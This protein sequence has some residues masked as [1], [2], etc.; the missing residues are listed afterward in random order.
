MKF[1][2]SS[3]A[4]IPCPSQHDLDIA[5][6]QDLSEDYA[7]RER[8]E[9][10]REIPMSKLTPNPQWDD[11]MDFARKY[12]QAARATA[13]EDDK[14][15]RF[16]DP[17]YERKYELAYSLITGKPASDRPEPKLYSARPRRDNASYASPGEHV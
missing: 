16:D 14:D 6:L 5:D 4:T 10:P 12:M 15:A 9:S 3:R 7:S 8:S 2:T 17:P 11:Y 1:A 13:V